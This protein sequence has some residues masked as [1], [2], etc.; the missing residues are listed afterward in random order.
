VAVS[1]LQFLFLPLLVLIEPDSNKEERELNQNIG[2]VMGVT[3]SEVE[4][5]M[6][7][8]MHQYRLKLFQTCV[9]ADAQRGTQSF[10][11]YAFPVRQGNFVDN[12]C[13]NLFRRSHCF[14]TTLLTFS[15]EK[16]IRT[17]KLIPMKSPLMWKKGQWRS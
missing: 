13:L 12:V 8:E 10:G 15:K 6:N 4:R 1:S 11:H 5:S 3:L 7:E 16:K 17:I 9:K 2:L 14:I